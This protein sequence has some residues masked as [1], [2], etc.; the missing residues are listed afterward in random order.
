MNMCKHARK[1]NYNRLYKSIICYVSCSLCITEGKTDEMR[2]H[3][4][5]KNLNR[6]RTISSLKS[7]G[8]FW[9]LST[10]FIKCLFGCNFLRIALDTCLPGSVDNAVY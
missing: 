5:K 2:T 10:H 8:M 9:V 7:G 3:I 4:L 1:E 6:L